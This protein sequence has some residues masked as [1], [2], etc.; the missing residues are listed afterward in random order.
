MWLALLW[1]AGT[2]PP[3]TAASLGYKGAL[4]FVLLSSHR[5]TSSPPLLQSTINL[6]GSD[7]APLEGHRSRVSCS[8]RP[9]TVGSCLFMESGSCW[10]GVPRSAVSAVSS[11]SA[12]NSPASGPSMAPF[13]S[14]RPAVFSAGKRNFIHTSC[15]NPKVLSQCQMCEL[16]FFFF[17]WILYRFPAHSSTNSTLSVEKDE[18]LRVYLSL[19]GTISVVLF[20]TTSSE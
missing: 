16:I 20:F 11:R 15:T 14:N 8:L 19:F 5:Y 9:K 3:Q 13:S 17:L 6:N 10:Q 7:S 1:L 4:S 12:G 2:E 18:L